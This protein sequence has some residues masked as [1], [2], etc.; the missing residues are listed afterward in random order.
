SGCLGGVAAAAGGDGDGEGKS[1]GSGTQTTTTS[2]RHGAAMAAAGLTEGHLM[3]RLL[4]VM[5]TV[6][7]RVEVVAG[8]SGV[9]GGMA[10]EV[11]AGSGVGSGCCHGDGW[12]AAGAAGQRGVW[13]RVVASDIMDRV[14]RVIRILFGFARKSMQKKFFGG[15][16]VVVAGWGWLPDFVGEKG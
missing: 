4:V 8:V 6:R 2:H 5:A 16:V 15:G 13:R 11:V 3:V 12:P 1:G 9:A 10:V 14:D 7:E